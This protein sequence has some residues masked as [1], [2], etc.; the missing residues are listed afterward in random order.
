MTRETRSVRILGFMFVFRS[1][2]H[3]HDSTRQHK[4]RRS[5]VNAPDDDG[6]TQVHTKE[7]KERNAKKILED[8][9]ITVPLTFF[10]VFLILFF[11]WT[12]PLICLLTFLK[13]L[14]HHSH[15]LL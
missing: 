9:G 4:T 12:W 14:I 6:K 13:S 8:S 5:S 11:V 10:L 2:E 3:E 15:S 7:T 1:E